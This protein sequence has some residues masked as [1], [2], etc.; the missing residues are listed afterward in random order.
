VNKGLIIDNE[1]GKLYYDD[2]FSILPIIPDKSVDCICTDPDFGKGK[3]SK[4][5]GVGLDLDLLFKHYERVLK[6]NG[7][8]IIFSHGVFSAKLMLIRE[9]MFKY[10]L[11]WKKDR[12][13]GH[14]NAKRQPLKNHE[15]I[16]IFYKKQPVYNPQKFKGLKPHS[17]GKAVNTIPL[18]NSMYGVHRRFNDHT[19]MKYPRT[20]LEFKAVTSS[21]RRYPT[22]K[23]IEL[24]TYLLKTYTNEG[25]VILDNFCGS[26][27]V[28]ESSII[29]NRRFICVDRELK[30][31]KLTINS[32]E[33]GIMNKPL[34]LF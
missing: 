15:D 23:P 33:K 21:K 29:N 9:K 19:D 18:E 3:V 1:Y 17:V 24:I 31:I 6:P 14:L 4:K 11:V 27:V 30:A 34:P 8:I 2:A 12:T 5:W 25:M 13:T 10:G 28:A 22:E 20:V 16:L 32:I 26:G 7:L